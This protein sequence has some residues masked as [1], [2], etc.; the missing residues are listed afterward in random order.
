MLIF[1]MPTV[2]LSLLSESSTH[3]DKW[4]VQCNL[5]L[6]GPLISNQ[7]ITYNSAGFWVSPVQSLHLATTFVLRHVIW[8]Q[9]LPFPWPSESIDDLSPHLHSTMGPPLDLVFSFVCDEIWQSPHLFPFNMC[10]WTRALN[11]TDPFAWPLFGNKSV[12]HMLGL[13]KEVCL[14]TLFLSV[15]RLHATCCMPQVQW[16][17]TLWSWSLS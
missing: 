11:G 9:R 5:A 6:C 14:C 10:D 17:Q 8:R 4:G 13:S 12:A 16:G 15:G 2:C 7:L 3:V 1:C